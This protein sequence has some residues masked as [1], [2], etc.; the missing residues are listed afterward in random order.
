[1]SLS[2]AKARAEASHIHTMSC[3]Y[4][5]PVCLLCHRH[6]LASCLD[7]PALSVVRPLSLSR[8]CLSKPETRS[9]TMLVS[10]VPRVRPHY[11]NK[12]C[13]RRTPFGTCSIAKYMQNNARERLRKRVRQ[14][15]YSNF[16]ILFISNFFVQ[17]IYISSY[18]LH[19]SSSSPESSSI[20]MAKPSSKSRIVAHSRRSCGSL[21][22]PQ[23]R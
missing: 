5:A 23:E 1:M 12:A 22:I 13:R 17:Q 6:A 20:G 4:L 9:T 15:N 16:I 18:F 10:H 7:K 14:N 19:G 2:G 11:T 8:A 21:K 3:T